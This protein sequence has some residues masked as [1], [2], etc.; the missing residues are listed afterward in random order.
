MTKSPKEC[1]IAMRQELAPRG[2]YFINAA[3]GSEEKRLL[4]QFRTCRRE[5]VLSPQKIGDRTLSGDDPPIK[6]EVLIT[7]NPFMLHLMGG[8]R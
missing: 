7:C 1:R 5:H 6:T 4:G 8:L 2:T 3:I